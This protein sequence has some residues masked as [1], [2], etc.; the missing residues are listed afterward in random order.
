MIFDCFISRIDQDPTLIP[1]NI[2]SYIPSGAPTFI[3]SNM[4]SNMP[5][6]VPAIET[7]LGP[8]SH[9]MYV[10]VWREWVNFNFCF[11]CVLLLLL[12]NVILHCNNI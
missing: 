1:T 4:P 6:D 11:V 12:V 9:G 8:V 5:S 2:P 7:S 3:A 10:Y